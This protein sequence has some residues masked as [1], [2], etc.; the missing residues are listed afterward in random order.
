MRLNLL[1]LLMLETTYV[2]LVSR[3]KTGP[4]VDTPER[5]GR[6]IVLVLQ[7]TLVGVV[8]LLEALAEASG[9]ILRSSVAIDVLISSSFHLILL[10]LIILL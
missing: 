3:Y 6:V 8:A 9:L 7:R 1:L 5:G 2:I 4:L 10:L